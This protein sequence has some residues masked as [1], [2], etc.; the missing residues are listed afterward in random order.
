MKKMQFEEILPYKAQD[1]YDLVMDLQRYPEI[2]DHIKKVEERDCGDHAKEAVVT[3]ATGIM[4]FRYRCRIEGTPPG[5]ITITSSDKPFKHMKAQWHF[6]PQPDGQTKVRYEMEYS[7]GFGL[8]SSLAERVMGHQVE[9]TRSH[10]RAYVSKN[11]TEVP[12]PPPPPA[13]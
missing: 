4:D 12:P 5:N 8:L 13:P 7:L 10:L 6:M 11:L 2:F 1:L 9:K 3:V